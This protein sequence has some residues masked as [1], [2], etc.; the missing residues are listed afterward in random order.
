MHIIALGVVL[1][2]FNFPVAG[3]I[4]VRSSPATY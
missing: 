1:H 3:R 2:L 4:L